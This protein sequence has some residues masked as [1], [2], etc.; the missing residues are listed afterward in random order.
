MPPPRSSTRR[1]ARR[2]QNCRRS[3]SMRSSRRATTSS[4]AW[5]GKGRRLSTRARRPCRRA[6]DVKQLLWH[7]LPCN[8]DDASALALALNLHPTV[9]RLLCLRGFGEPAVADRFLNPS[10]DH[11]HDPFLLKDMERAVTR[12]ERALAGGERI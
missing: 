5:D 12:L 11:L 4:G 8:E 7:H 2:C 10:L 1:S 3:R 9:A 6:A